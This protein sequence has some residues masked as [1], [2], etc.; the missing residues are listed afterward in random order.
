MGYRDSILIANGYQARYER[1]EKCRG[2][3]NTTVCHA[4]KD[5]VDYYAFRDPGHYMRIMAVQDSI[6]NMAKFSAMVQD[7]ALIE[8]VRGKVL[9]ELR[10]FELLRTATEEDASLDET[11]ASKRIRLE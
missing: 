2:L 8:M 1:R 6:P 7:V 3:G 9:W 10:R 4:S 5:G 11:T